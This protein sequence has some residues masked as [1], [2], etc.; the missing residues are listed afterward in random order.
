MTNIN[1]FRDLELESINSIISNI[2]KMVNIIYTSKVPQK[3]TIYLYIIFL[4]L[5]EFRLTLDMSKR[6]SLQNKVL[7]YW[8]KSFS[9]YSASS[10]TH[11]EISR[12]LNDYFSLQYT[13]ELD[14]S[15]SLSSEANI[16]IDA[17]SILSKL[18][19]DD[20]TKVKRIKVYGK[21]VNVYHIIHFFIT[22]FLYIN[23]FF[24]SF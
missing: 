22:T 23:I 20:K 1:I 24:N 7:S 15:D 3:N 6:S 14:A 16:L 4:K 12:K 13:N 17:S 19:N 18:I 5:L 11:D 8:S 9:Q 10:N 2:R 21:D